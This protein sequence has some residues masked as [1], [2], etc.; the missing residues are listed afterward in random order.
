[1]NENNHVNDKQTANQI[2][3]ALT[4]ASNV[5]IVG[6]SV[7]GTEVAMAIKKHSEVS[8]CHWMIVCFTDT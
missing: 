1:V 2:T 3:R 4:G 6:T 8:G 7:L 5:V